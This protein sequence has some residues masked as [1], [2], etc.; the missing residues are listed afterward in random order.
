MIYDAV[1]LA[2]GSPTDR[3]LDIPGGDKAG[4]IGSAA[5]VGWYNGHPEFRDLDPDL[6]VGAAAVIGNGTVAIDC[7]RVLAQTPAGMAQ[8]DLTAY[9]IGRAHVRTPVTNE[10][11][12]FRI[13]IEET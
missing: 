13:M 12:V 11:L 3:P 2:I 4:V 1:V 7:A 6:N 5:F 9:V 8:S 10:Q